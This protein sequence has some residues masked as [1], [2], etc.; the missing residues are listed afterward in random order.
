[1]STKH[2]PDIPRPLGKT[3]AE[4]IADAMADGV[5]TLGTAMA[6]ANAAGKRNG[7]RLTHEQMYA[8]TEALAAARL[9]LAQEGTA[10]QIIRADALARVNNA[11]AAIAKA[12][13]SN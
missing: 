1:M 9:A 6:M 2:T 10:A 3:R 8:V 12:L 4:F 7:Y 11:C 13:G 5:T